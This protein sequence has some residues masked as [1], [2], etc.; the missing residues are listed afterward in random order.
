MTLI[1]EPMTI[2]HRVADLFPLMTAEDFETLK[3]DIQAHGLREPIVRY[4]GAIIDG[5]HRLQICEQLGIQPHFREFQGNE[6]ELLPFVLSM[7]LARRHLTAS[8]RAA[9]GAKIEAYLSKFSKA[10]QVAVAFKRQEQIR[11]LQARL[12]RPD[13]SYE[14][15]LVI[16]DELRRLKGSFATTDRR[17]EERK[18]YFIQSGER[19]KMGVSENPKSRLEV[20]RIGN[21]D[22]TLR[23]VIL[24]G[25]ELEQALHKKY[26]ADRIKGEWF[27]L[28][29]TLEQEI[30]E[31]TALG[32]HSQTTEAFHARRE[33]AKQVNVNPHYITDF[34]RLE[35]HDPA[36]ANQVATGK[37]SVPEALRELTNDN[38]HVPGSDEPPIGPPTPER[39][40]KK[41][42]TLTASW[43]W[44]EPIEAFVKS[45]MRGYSLNVCSGACDLGDVRV[46][47]D[48]KKPGVIKADMRDLPFADES[49]GTVLSDPPWRTSWFDRW[50]PF[51]EL[52][53]VCKVG[54][55]IIFNSYY[56]PWSKQV[57]M[58]ELY[59]RQDERF[60]NASILSM[61]ERVANR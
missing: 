33:A 26:A 2:F 27:K 25:Y 31:L 17:V 29:D 46:D 10:R 24:G 55:Q 37:L 52:V 34:K 41:N 42:A 38:G 36:L 49:F 6:I 56:V 13:Q 59:V 57:K 32:I 43:T 48:P 45:R 51:F 18:V 14:M 15:R 30:V 44:P 5:R 20:L 35:T 21:P 53:R 16:S 28:S 12:D 11:Q 40:L 8:Q 58:T 47:L 4:Q 19:I 61:F 39:L 54:G 1:V 7:N 50:R 22:C 60:A 23:A 9:L 3:N